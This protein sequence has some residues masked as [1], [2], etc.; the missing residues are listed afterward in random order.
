MFLHV[1]RCLNTSFERAHRRARAGDLHR[2][3][4]SE[5]LSRVDSSEVRNTPPLEKFDPLVGQH[6]PSSREA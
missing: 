5:V 6:A 3:D 1:Q 4:S 2:V